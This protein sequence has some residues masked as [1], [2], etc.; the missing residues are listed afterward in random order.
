MTLRA[1]ISYF[2]GK[3]LE[4]FYFIIYSNVVK[5]CKEENVIYWYK[6]ATSHHLQSNN[7]TLKIKWKNYWRREQDYSPD[8][9]FFFLFHWNFPF[10]LFILKYLPSYILITWEMWRQSY[11]T[12]MPVATNIRFTANV[13]RCFFRFIS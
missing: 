9:V 2:I 12:V 6:N 11:S 1:T 4:K 3:N 7:H 5:K 8:F 10:L 13:F